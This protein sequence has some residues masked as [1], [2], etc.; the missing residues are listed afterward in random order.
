MSAVAKLSA[1]IWFVLK[2]DIDTRL[3]TSIINWPNLDKYFGGLYS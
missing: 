3:L 1:L 2:V